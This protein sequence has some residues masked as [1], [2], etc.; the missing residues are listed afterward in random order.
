MNGIANHSESVL[1]FDVPELLQS[2]GLDEHRKTWELFA[3]YG[4]ASFGGPSG[5]A[6]PQPQPGHQASRG[7]GL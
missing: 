6:F 5:G 4:E 3:F 1:V 7:I 2:V